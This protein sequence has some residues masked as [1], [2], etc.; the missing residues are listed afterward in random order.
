[1][2]I[3]TTFYKYDLSTKQK[4]I[5]DDKKFHFHDPF[6][7]HTLNSWL[8]P[9]EF[10]KTTLKYLEQES[11]KNLLLEG[12]IGDH[13]IRFAFFL[14]TKK[15]MFDYIN[16]LFYWQDKDKNEVD[17]ILYDGYNIEI[18]IEVKYTRDKISRTQLTGFLNFREINNLKNGLIITNDEFKIEEDY[19][20]IPASIFL[21]LI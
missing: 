16:Y 20:K 2:F 6:F 21:L 7:F 8:R 18:Q 17:Y 19:I 5:A 4:R 3:L 12:V 11:T 10:F 9:E 13:L 1:M 15:Y 14:S